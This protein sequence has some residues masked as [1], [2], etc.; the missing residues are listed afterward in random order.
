MN[1]AKE[2]FLEL[3]ENREASCWA[4]LIN[5]VMFL[6]LS[7]TSSSLSASFLI[8]YGSVCNTYLTR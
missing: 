6:G 1:R 5:Q 4:C 3:L 7:P 8:L 2:F